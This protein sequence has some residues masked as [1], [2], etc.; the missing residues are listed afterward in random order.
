MAKD[1]E[2]LHDE[3]RELY[4]VKN[5]PLAE[6]MRVVKGKHGFVAS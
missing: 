4:H 3:I 2:P 5:K 1:W 6:V